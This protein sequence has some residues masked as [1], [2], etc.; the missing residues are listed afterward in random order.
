LKSP[1]L[2]ATKGASEEDK[3]KKIDSEYKKLASADDEKEHKENNNDNVR[4][5]V[6]DEIHLSNEEIQVQYIKLILFLIC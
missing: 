2:A 1:S 5:N 3:S 6:G 4:E